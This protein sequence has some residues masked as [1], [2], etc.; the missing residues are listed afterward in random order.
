M[1]S[2]IAYLFASVE[3]GH[4][5]EAMKILRDKFTA[6]TVLQKQA[7]NRD[8]TLLSQESTGFDVDSFAAA[9]KLE[10]NKLRDMGLVIS[11]VEMSSTFLNGLIQDFHVIKAQMADETGLG[12]FDLVVSKVSNY[13]KNCGL[14]NKK[15]KS[16]KQEGFALTASAE[17]KQN[18]CNN[19]RDTGSCRFG[20]KCKYKHVKGKT[21]EEG[22]KSDVD[23]FCSKC[24]KAGHLGKD[25][26]TAKQS[27]GMIAS[28]VQD[29]EESGYGK[30]HNYSLPMM[31]TVAASTT[32]ST[33]FGIDS[34]ASSHLT[35]DRDDF[36][37]G[38]L[39]AVN[40]DFKI[41]SGGDITVLEEGDISIA[42]GQ[43]GEVVKLRKVGYYP[44]LPFKLISGGRL[45][46]AGFQIEHGNEAGKMNICKD[47]VKVFHARVK[48]NA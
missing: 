34:F 41:G 35:N 43:N 5:E 13:A 38:S 4:V 22:S 28:V 48:D 31:M 25:C 24:G 46:Q 36:I 44:G 1:A 40:I 39:Q 19:F 9:I 21:K 14:S 11:E 29:D 27:K 23:G 47:G 3:F 17:K 26:K 42:Q 45:F 30:G 16:K 6:V 8:F 32:D 20:D 15:V 33:T 12:N 2:D 10:A 37:P 7:A 18:E